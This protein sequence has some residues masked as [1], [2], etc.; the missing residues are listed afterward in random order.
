VNCPTPVETG[1][2]AQ[3]FDHYRG[4]IIKKKPAKRST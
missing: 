4:D 1:Y 3:N 2:E